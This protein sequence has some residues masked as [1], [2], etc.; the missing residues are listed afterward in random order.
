MTKKSA[1]FKFFLP[2]LLLAVMVFL[3]WKPEP[4]PQEQAWYVSVYCRAS[5][6]N[7]TSESLQAA[8]EGSQPGAGRQRFNRQAASEVLGAWKKLDKEQQRIARR[9]EA[10][11][12]RLLLD[13][14]AQ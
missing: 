7:T 3:F 4:N 11:C 13:K 14:L 9:D 12:R 1:L 10:Q 8:V 6:G 2:A 5:A